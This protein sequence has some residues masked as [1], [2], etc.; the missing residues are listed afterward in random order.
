MLIEV[1]L[2]GFLGRTFGARHRLDVRSTA[3]AI[4]ALDANF[5]GFRP[6]LVAYRW[7]FHVLRGEECLDA[8]ELCLVGDDR[9]LHLIPALQGGQDALQM[10]MGAVLIVAG[11][12]IPGAQMLMFTGALMLAGGIYSLVSGPPQGYDGESKSRDSY[13]FDGPLQTVGAGNPVPVG[14]GEL[15]VGGVV[16][17]AGIFVQTDGIETVASNTLP[18]V[19][20]WPARTA[21]AGATTGGDHVPVEIADNISST[22]SISAL[23]A[24]SEGAIEGLATP[25][26]PLRSVYLNGVPVR[27]PGDSY[28]FPRVRLWHR[29]GYPDQSPIEEMPDV[30][31]EMDVGVTVTHAAPVPVTIFE[32]GIDKVQVTVNCTGLWRMTGK[33]DIVGHSVTWAVEVALNGGPSVEKVR[34]TVSRKSSRGFM[35]ALTV[36]LDAPTDGVHETRVKLVRIS[37]DDA[38]SK[39]RS[40]FAFYSYTRIINAK[41]N[42][43]NTALALI[44]FD[45]KSFS[46]IPTI[47]FH[48]KMLRVRVPSNYD[49][50]TRHYDG[51]WDGT[52]KMAYTRN[53]AW[54]FYD[55]ATDTRYGAGRH[56]AGVVNK[57]LLYQVARYCDEMVDSGFTNDAGQV[58]LEP[59][60]RC[61]VYLQTRDEAYTVLN[62]LASVFR[63][64]LYWAGGELRCGQDRPGDAEWLFTPGN[65]VDGRF[66][67]AGPARRSRITV[68]LVAW[69]DPNDMGR[70]KIE[71]VSD[72]DAVKKY[73]WRESQVVAVGCTSLGQAH[74]VG[75]WMLSA[76]G[77]TVAFQVGLEG[78]AIYPGCIVRIAD[79]KRD[80]RRTGGRI[81]SVSEDLR[82]VMLDADVRLVSGAYRLAVILPGGGLAM[83]E[84]TDPPGTYRMLTLS[85]PLPT[86]PVEWAVWSLIDGDLRPSLWRIMSITPSKAGHT[87]DVKAV[88]YNP[89]KYDR[90]ETFTVDPSDYS[91][92]IP[93]TIDAV[94]SA[95]FGSRVNAVTQAVVFAAGAKTAGTGQQSRTL[96]I[97]WAE[98]PFA[99]YYEWRWRRDEGKWSAMQISDDGEVE[100][101]V[102]TE[103]DSLYYVSVVAVSV[104]GPKSPAVESPG[105]SG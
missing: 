55:M 103:A 78:A 90:I 26:F 18:P 40:E 43:P 21:I 12:M 36:T 100:I 96:T 73:G 98:V 35:R 39:H 16:I 24:L 9:P 105:V 70:R 23:I 47:A 82:Q 8:Q 77:D 64:I 15:F 25:D 20:G 58:V 85:A 69:N 22:A 75:R 95:T 49:A 63:G 3:E 97:W 56:L 37:N 59:R 31:S 29:L 74:R 93:Q 34:E 19:G 14:Y 5:P 54:I 102:F 2:H 86:Q 94:D 71:P 30:R 53:P 72:P 60:F 66:V 4:G 84:I 1:H 32:A 76:E 61:D 81:A 91:F 51:V 13:G 45:A 33:G 46:R 42:Y 57:W 41:L 7:G 38:D 87:A 27:G 92:R 65:V 68:A 17:S 6:A 67:Y 99:A 48:L 50:A 10:I 62:N 101:P 28:N 104:F 80:G 89:D 11:A 88:A 44:K 83:I 52:F 79:P